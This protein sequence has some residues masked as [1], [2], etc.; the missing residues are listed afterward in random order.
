[1]LRTN[2]DNFP[3][4]KAFAA[5]LE[6]LLSRGIFNADGLELGSVTVRS[7]AFRVIALEV[8]SR[9]LPVL[10]AATDADAV[11][12]LLDVFRRFVALS[13]ARHRR[14]AVAVEGQ[15]PAQRRV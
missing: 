13:H 4:G 12:D 14:G 9:V 10:T 2:F 15:A 6:D 5:L 1:M 8:E 11:F 7:Y 3:K